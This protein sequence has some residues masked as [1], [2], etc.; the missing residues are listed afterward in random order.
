MTDEELLGEIE[1]IIR[2]VPPKKT[3]GHH[4]DENFNW[5]GRAAAALEQWNPTKGRR[6]KH[7]IND[8]QDSM[9]RTSWEGYRKTLTTLHQA[10]HELR[11]KTIGPMNTS[12]SQGMTFHYFDEIRKVIESANQDILFVDPYLDAEFVSRYLPHVKSGVVVRLLACKLLK[13]LLP[14]VENYAQQEQQSIEVRS[15]PD[16]HDRYIFIDGTSCHQ[17]GASFKDGAKKSHTTITQITDVFE[18]MYSA[19]Q[20]IWKNAKAEV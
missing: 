8:I 7:D 15:T 6:A 13:T 18:A 4:T 16:I 3:I 10:G 14:A 19:Y 1:D 17:S 9:S 5:L 12:V 11:M 20:E 2:N